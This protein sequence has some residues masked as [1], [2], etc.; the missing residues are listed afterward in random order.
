M[1]RCEDPLGVDQGSTTPDTVGTLAYQASLPG[2]LRNL[3][4]LATN[5]LGR[6]LGLTT[7]AVTTLT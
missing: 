1:S 4:L 6:S 7:G 2:I 5:Y 3:R